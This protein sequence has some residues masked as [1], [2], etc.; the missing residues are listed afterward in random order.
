MVG[1][2]GCFIDPF[3]SSGVYLAMTGGLSAGTTIAASIRRDVDETTATRW[4]NSQ[5]REGYARFLLVV[6]SVYK[7]MMNQDEPML[8]DYNEDNFDRA[9]S[10]FTPGLSSQRHTKCKLT[11]ISVTQGT[12]E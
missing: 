5:V 12:V 4:H 1:D 2:A 9:F 11:S 10:F 7:Q 3:F 6:W 8:S